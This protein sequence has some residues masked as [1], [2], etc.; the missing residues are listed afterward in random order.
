MRTRALGSQTAG[1]LQQVAA[2]A[3]SDL[4]GS[5]QQ[6]LGNASTAVGVR[7][8]QRGDAG[9]GTTFRET[10]DPVQRDEAGASPASS[11][12]FPSPSASRRASTADGVAG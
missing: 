2:P 12:L 10:L 9:E 7:H 6:R 11:T 3:A 5:A 8:D 1:D 4:L